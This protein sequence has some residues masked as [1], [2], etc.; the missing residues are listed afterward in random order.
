MLDELKLRKTCSAL[1]FVQLETIR[2]NVLGA[3]NLADICHQRG[4]HLTV[5]AT[6]CIFHYDETK[7]Q[8]SNIGFTEEDTPNFTGSYYSR[9]KVN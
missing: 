8:G 4:V 5:F 1:C 2:A 3:L 9:T 7:S 6:G